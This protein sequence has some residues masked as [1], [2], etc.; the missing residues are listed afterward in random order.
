MPYPDGPTAADNL[1]PGCR[2]HHRCKQARG[3]RVTQDS[4][5]RL[6]WASPTG[7]VY[8]TEPHTLPVTDPRERAAPAP[9]QSPPEPEHHE[10][11]F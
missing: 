8:L 4:E 9:G 7:H 2:G 6:H 3:W 5:R 11:P 1:H 10:P